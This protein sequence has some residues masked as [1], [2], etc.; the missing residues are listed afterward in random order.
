MAEYSYDQLLQCIPYVMS[1]CVLSFLCAFLNYM[2]SCSFMG[3]ARS[4]AVKRGGGKQSKIFTIIKKT[5]YIRK[6]SKSNPV[7]PPPPISHVCPRQIPQITDFCHFTLIQISIL[8]FYLICDIT[9]SSTLVFTCIS[10]FGGFF[11]RCNSDTV[12]KLKLVLN[13]SPFH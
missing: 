6:S 1:E 9:F 13:F 11:S 8:L 7:I 2:C 5:L 4:I 10:L 3:Q 12:Y